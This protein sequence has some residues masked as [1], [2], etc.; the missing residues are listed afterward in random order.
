MSATTEGEEK[1][2]SSSSSSGSASVS[3]ASAEAAAAAASSSPTRKRKSDT[4]VVASPTRALTSTP[5]KQRTDNNNTLAL[6]SPMSVLCTPPRRMAN[7]ATSATLAC[8]TPVTGPLLPADE[9]V[10]V[11]IRPSK[12]TPKKDVIEEIDL[13]LSDR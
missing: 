7:A 3:E 2:E 12:L 11:T 4:A 10:P 6:P 5:K 1:R 13:L 8:T 9:S